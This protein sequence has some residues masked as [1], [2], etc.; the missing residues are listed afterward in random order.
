M[1]KLVVS[2]LFAAA[3]AA[4]LAPLPAQARPRMVCNRVWVRGHWVRHC[5]P[6]PPPR[7]HHH[8]PYRR[9]VPYR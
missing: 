7:Y 3:A 2:L 9:P 5:R 4:S 1:R 8:R 6:L